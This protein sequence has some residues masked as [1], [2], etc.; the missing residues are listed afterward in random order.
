M[1]DLLTKLRSLL[2]DRYLLDREIGAGRLA[3]VFLAQDVRHGRK[4]AVKALRPE[5]IGDAV[6]GRFVR[7]IEIAASLTHPNI[8]PVFDSGERSGIPFFVMPFEEGGTLRYRLDREGELSIR[9]AVRLAHDILEGLRCAHSHGI[10]HL[11]VKPENVLLSPDHALLADFGVARIP[12]EEDHQ[13]GWGPGYAVGTPTYMSPEQAD[14]E[15]RQD[16][17]SDLYSVGCVLYEML[18]GKPPFKGFTSQ[19]VL[20][21]HLSETPP[22][23][24]LSRPTVPKELDTI[25]RKALRKT[26]ADRFSDAD[27][28]LRALRAVPLEDEDPSSPERSMAKKRHPRLGP[29]PGP[30]DGG[31]PTSVWIV[32]DHPDYRADVQSV[33]DEEGDLVCS[34]VFGSAEEMIASLNEHWAPDVVLMDIGLPGM[35]G[36]EATAQIKSSWPGTEVIMLTVHDDHDRIFRAFEAGAISYLAKRATDDEILR[37]VRAAPRGGSVLTPQVA[38]RFLGMFKQVQS[39]A[40]AYHLSPED[41]ELLSDLVS[42]KSAEGI[43]KERSMELD[44]LRIR[45]RLIH[46]KLHVNCASRLSDNG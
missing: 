20:A 14:P 24:A 7:E 12:T 32:E 18:S 34:M 40:G 13:K 45:L 38:R 37:A 4:V 2:E 10:I 35:D 17:R 26:A 43:A 41:A 15:A 42:G 3:R 31:S 16:P 19:A 1:V 27:A 30:E 22:S 9:D 6:A 46:A 21:K 44:A 39:V 11:D 25:V 23:I 33:L 36:I 28:F 8:V 5:R 29:T